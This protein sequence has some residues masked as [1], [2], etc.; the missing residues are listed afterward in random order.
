MPNGNKI[1]RH[2]KHIQIEQVVSTRGDTHDTI[3]YCNQII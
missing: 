3:K 1:D 2:K